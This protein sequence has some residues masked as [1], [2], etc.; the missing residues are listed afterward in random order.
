MKNL[1]KEEILSILLKCVGEYDDKLRNYQ[2]LIVYQNNGTVMQKLVGFR[3]INFLHLTG[4]R[5]RY[6]AT[7]YILLFDVIMNEVS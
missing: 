1:K 4:L 3:D 6:G 7:Y 5:S 2:F